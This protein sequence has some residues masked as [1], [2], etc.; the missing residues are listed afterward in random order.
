MALGM[1]RI[2]VA[3]LVAAVLT[4]AILTVFVLKPSPETTPS[5]DQPEPQAVAAPE[6]QPP[7]PP[8]PMKE[9]PPPLPDPGITVAEGVSLEETAD[10]AQRQAVLS[11]AD[12][13]ANAS[14]L[15]G[16]T[17][18]YP[19]DESVF[20]PDMVAPTFLWHDQE[21]QADQWLIDIDLGDGR[22]IYALTSGGQ[23]P[24]GQIDPDCLGATNE[25][26]TPTEYQASAE[27]W[28]PDEDLWQAVTAYSTDRPASVTITGFAS[29]DAATPL[30]RGA[31]TLMTS[32][33]PVGA[34]I[35][36]RDV[37]LMPAQSSDGTIS[38]LANG[39]LPLV[40]WR[41]R[42]V[43]RHD[44]RVVLSDMATCGN[45]H[46]FSADG[47]T[48]GM[49][50]DGP[51]G[52]KGM[53]TLAP[54]KETI[55]IQDDNVLTWNS[56]DGKPEGHK[57]IGF[58]SRVSPDGRHVISTVNES[59][60][61]VN[62]MDYRFLQ[63]FYPTGGILAVY[64]RQTRDIVPLP[65]AD[66]PDYV[67]C[68]PVWTPDGETIVFARAK[69]APRFQQDRPEATKAGDP[70]EL[71]MQYD[72]YRLPFNGGRG[73]KAVPIE[74]AS[75]NGMSNTFAKVSPDGKWVVFV[76]CANGQLMRPDSELWIVPLAGGAAR[77]M[78]CNT[79]LMNSW[80]SFSPNGRWLVFSS[81]CNTPYTQMFLTHLDADGSDTPPILIPGATAANRAVNI[82]EFVNIG[83]DDLVRI[84]TPVLG[85]YRFI[86]EGDRLVKTGRYEQAIAAYK[87]A[88]QREPE[89]A[90]AN[91]GVG[92]CHLQFG[93]F[94]LA[95]KYLR[96]AV[97][98]DPSRFRA[99]L[100][101]GGALAE[102][103]RPDE[104]IVCYRRA[105]GIYPQSNL[106]YVNLGSLLAQKGQPDEAIA[107]F[108]QALQ[109]HPDSEAAHFNL[110]LTLISV[111]RPVDAIRHFRKV[112]DLNPNDAQAHVY[113]GAILSQR[114][115]RD[116]AID[117]FR[118]ALAVDPNNAD[119]HTQWGILLVR[120]GLLDEAIGHFREALKIAPDNT[121][122][123]QNLQQALQRKRQGV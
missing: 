15:S 45:C 7:V 11:L 26:Y 53:Y 108:K 2:A 73:G 79:S 69:A 67:H 61:V 48:M 20:P 104:A 64:S 60:Y 120:E 97:E 81:K 107:Q 114:N 90:R 102:L 49:D 32:T 95:E 94:Q 22:H 115:A 62:F 14:D 31:M 24:R 44:S 103:G 12:A 47:K 112:L 36:Y 21:P 52:D 82:P 71:P 55:V 84:E 80:H 30:S 41:L 119:A 117:H 51:N 38:P 13:A 122:A 16:V 72:L 93:R 96:H 17:V 68:D 74:G 25:I 76:K 110:A 57:T 50:V 58:L 37:P 10:D 91:Y 87:E 92:A 86:N 46:S 88:L 9:D 18:D 63:V 19:L 1:K 59:V 113:L 35:F 109:I 123:M 70:N 6:P 111:H 54:V 33:D 85:H 34:P 98:L 39:V 99:Q 121:G 100:D 29:G 65:G 118:Q 101:L 75:A 106:A 89:S 116:E 3:A 28:T 23:A 4:A 40:A 77:R 5:D 42:D 83:Y 27:S 8:A 78:A 66:D 56:F 43:G 105:L